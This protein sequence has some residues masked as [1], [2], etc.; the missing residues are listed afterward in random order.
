MSVPSVATEEYVLTK[1]SHAVVMNPRLHAIA[2]S[3]AIHLGAIQDE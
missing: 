3:S 1:H 2:V